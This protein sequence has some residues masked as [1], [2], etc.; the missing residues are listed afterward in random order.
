MYELLSGDLL[1]PR[2]ELTPTHV[3]AYLTEV[4]AEETRRSLRLFAKRGWAQLQPQTPIWNWHMDAI[5]DHLSY[6]TLGE[7]RFLMVNIGPRL[8]KTM[9]ISVLWPD[10]HWLHI[11]GEQFLTAG[12]DDQLARDAAILSRRL[13]ESPWYQTQ[14]PGE[15]EL[16]DDE[17]TAGMYRNRKGGYRMIGSLQGRITGVG[18]TTQILDD[19]HDAKK[20]ESDKVRHNALAWHDNAWRSRVN[21]PDQAKKVY[22]GQRTHD[23]DIF[24]HVLEREGARWCHLILPMEYDPGRRCITFLN[25]G[26][27]DPRPADVKPIFL[28]PRTLENEIIDPKRMSAKTVNA[29]KRNVSEAAWQAQYNQRPAGTG[30]L[31]LK[32]HWWRAWVQPEWRTNAGAERPM[33]R[34]DKVIQVWDTAFEED[35]EADFSACTTWGIFRYTEQ[36]MEK[37]LHRPADFPAEKPVSGE[38]RTCMMLLHALEDRLTYPDLRQQAIDL[39]KEF[40]PIDVVLVEKKA[41][42]HS[43]VQELR[44]KHVPVKAVLLSG[45]SG[46][47]GREGDLVARAHSASL[48]L[49]KGCVWYMPRPFSY[50]VMEECSKFPNGDHDD[51]VSSCV[52]AWMYAR[53]YYDLQLPD[54]EQDEISPWA[55][56]KLPPKRYA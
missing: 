55:W 17:N 7:I 12:V 31:I 24:G 25:N 51:Y 44:K 34:F 47:A 49:E 39:Y 37:N 32:R 42:G 23:T 10:W 14:Y 5:C 27:G 19:P 22:V 45:S 13:V 41:S 35:E 8:S 3:R 21:N 29:E 6:V 20:I 52:I 50:A 1:P 36:Y 43:L 9:L 53:R 54:D 18:G 4:A 46:K 11:P 16:F 56:K 33:P 38:T 28:D 30:G 26:D 40:A 48:M 15:I 2:A